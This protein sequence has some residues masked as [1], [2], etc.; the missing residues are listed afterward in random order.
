MRGATRTKRTA[1][2]RPSDLPHASLPGQDGTAEGVPDEPPRFPHRPQGSTVHA[3]P[4][5][6]GDTP[7]ALGRTAPAASSGEPNG[8][9]SRERGA[10]AGPGLARGATIPRGVRGRHLAPS[11]GTPA[12]RTGVTPGPVAPATGAGGHHRATAPHAPAAPTSLTA[13]P[14]VPSSA[15]AGP[16]HHLNRRTLAALLAGLTLGL[17]SDST[18]ALAHDGVHATARHHPPHAGAPIWLLGTSTALAIAVGITML[19]LGTR[20]ATRSH[21]PNTF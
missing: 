2:A 17:L 14:A 18:S 15:T 11:G 7:R 8:L 9:P 4:A 3:V 10:A 13:G 21:H 5:T 19:V 16:A 20:Q 6:C 1:P 12:R